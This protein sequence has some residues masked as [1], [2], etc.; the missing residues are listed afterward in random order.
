[1]VFKKLYILRNDRELRD[2]VVKVDFTA[3]S[4]NNN[5]DFM[6]QTILDFK[7]KHNVNRDVSLLLLLFKECLIVSLSS[8][9]MHT[10]EI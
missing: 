3:V 5:C 7:L 1:M 8:G 10:K 6:F 4:I 2:D 9:C